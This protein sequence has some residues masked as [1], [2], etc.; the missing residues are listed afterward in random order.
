MEMNILS[1]QPKQKIFLKI[2]ENF[3]ENPLTEHK[4]EDGGHVEFC[5]SFLSPYF[6][7]KLFESLI[8]LEFKQ[9]EI[10]TYDGKS[11]LTPRLQAWMGD[12]NINASI[13]T[14]L[15]PNPWSKEM[16]ILKNK[17]EEITKFKF[18]YVLI[19]YYRDGKDY[20][21]Y[22]SDKEAIGNGKNVICSISLGAT[23]KFV[24][25]HLDKTIPKRSFMLEN[26]SL[27]IM[28]GDETQVYWKHT[29]TQTKIAKNLRISLTF[30]HS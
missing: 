20:I 21:S 8:T 15:D 6:S 28:K 18:D 19:N 26:G 24:L 30:R 25:K 12:N 2:I 27:I 29:I 9:S 10:I 13:Y 17:L 3:T 11:V 22:H 16:L 5:E 4:L 23:R 1:S 14:I 7:K